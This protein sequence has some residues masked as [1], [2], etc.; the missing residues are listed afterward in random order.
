MIPRVVP[1][2]GSTSISGTGMMG[3]VAVI[4]PE[5]PMGTLRRF[6][7]QLLRRARYPLRA[8]ER[9]RYLRESVQ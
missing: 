1:V 5:D 8:R 2:L 7:W 6:D 3:E 9:L 4:R